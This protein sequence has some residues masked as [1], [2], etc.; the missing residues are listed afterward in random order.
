MGWACTQDRI[1]KGLFGR[2]R[3]RYEDDIKTDLMEKVCEDGT[4]MKLAQ[5]HVQWRT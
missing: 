5:N 2:P 3:R 4:W 1:R